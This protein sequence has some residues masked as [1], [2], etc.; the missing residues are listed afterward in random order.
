MPV[1]SP[2]H[3]AVDVNAISAVVLAEANRGRRGVFIHNNTGNDLY[4]KFGVGATPSSFT[5]KMPAG[6]FYE[7]P[8]LPIYVGVVTGILSSGDGVVQ[9]TELYG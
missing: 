1:T 9:V 7:F 5:V 8:G 4:V 3:E 6:S 2:Q